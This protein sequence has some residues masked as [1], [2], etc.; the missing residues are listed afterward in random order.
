MAK[1]S[2]MSRGTSRRSFRRGTGTH[3]KNLNFGN[4]M[5]GGIRM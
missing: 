5:R 4:P 2:H 1:R 3:I